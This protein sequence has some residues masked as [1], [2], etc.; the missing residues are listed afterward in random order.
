MSD[1][2]RSAGAVALESIAKL[3]G[4][5][6]AVDGVSLTVEPGT[7]FT[8]LGPSGCGKSTLLRMIAGL[9]DPSSGRVLIDGKDVTGLSAQRRPTAMVFQSYALF[10]TMT[11]GD[12]VEYGL[13]VR[14][15]PKAVRAERVSAALN[16]V[17]MGHLAAR[18]V[19]ALSGGQQQ[20]VAL[21]RALVVEPAVMLFDEPLSNLDVALREQTRA[22]LRELQQALGTTSIYVTHDQ[23][24][25][26]AISDVMAVMRDGRLVQVGPPD[27]LYRNPGTAYVAGFLGGSN[28]IQDRA[29]A[30]LLFP[31]GAPGPEGSVLS[32]RP[33]DLRSDPDGAVQ[34]VVRSRQFL[35]PHV[36]W[37]VEVEHQMLRLRIPSDTTLDSNPRLSAATAG[38]VINDL[39]TSSP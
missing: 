25:A 37:E 23:Q 3:F 7:F 33:E 31:G 18:P 30:G 12:N 15:I 26:M 24:E 20:R 29:L 13:R 36:E 39:K 14:R 16:R 19:T 34:G 6:R 10:P 32:I 17:G 9:E 27:E 28:I 4:D 5:V 11:V 38:W 35:G 22:E 2:G 21:A 8:L 1:T